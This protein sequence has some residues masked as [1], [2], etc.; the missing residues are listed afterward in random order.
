[1]RMPVLG[2][3]SRGLVAAAAPVHLSKF[4]A[5]LGCTGFVTPCFIR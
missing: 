5:P 1:M 4:G 3:L 2:L